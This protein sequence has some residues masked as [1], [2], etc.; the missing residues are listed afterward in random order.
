MT[1]AERRQ[2]AEVLKKRL[3]AYVH[4]E[5]EADRKALQEIWALG[6]AERVEA[7]ECLA[8][9]VR[10]A[11]AAGDGVLRLRCEDFSAKFR[12]GEPLFLGEGHSIESGLPVVFEGYDLERGEVRVRRDRFAAGDREEIPEASE[13]Q[14]DKRGRHQRDLLLAGV[15]SVFRPENEDVVDALLGRR[16]TEPDASRRLAGEER[17][18]ALGLTERQIEALGRTVSTESVALVH[19]PPG[20]G[21]TRVLAEAALA[22]ARRRCRLF[23]TA[24]THRA[25]DNLLLSIRALS[26]ELPVFK[27]R[28]REEPEL[29]RARISTLRNL[30][31]SLP[32]PA[33]I[34]GTPYSVCR[35]HPERRFHFVLIDEA[36][37]MP[38][39]HGAIA[40]TQ[41]RRYIVAGDP[42]QLSPVRVGAHHDPNLKP[43]LFE[44]LER[45]YESVLLDR[46]FR[47]TDGLAGW[48]SEEFYGGQLSSAEGVGSARL[49][50]KD[51]GP[52]HEVLSPD[53]PLVLARV[54]HEGRTR[55]SREEAALVADLVSALLGHHE[56]PASEIA[57]LTPFRAQV[58]LIRHELGRRGLRA[59]DLV[60]D[61][62][63]RMQG[64]ER[65]VVLLSL[66]SSDRD[67]LEG[68]A[69]FFFDPGRLNVAL[70]R[71]R[72]KCIIVASRHAFRARPNE[73]PALLAATRFKRL[74]AAAFVVDLTA[75]YA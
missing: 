61:T 19:G 36:G 10:V 41:A 32:R 42:R 51:G 73:L 43:S 57:V 15:D 23:V 45:H 52:L 26:P 44:F 55:R 39:V 60:V 28:R 69:E 21:K 6:V 8:G 14:L 74:S 48:I 5:A 67:Y 24:Y 58:R 75:S 33:V 50:A 16:R 12:E 1:D 64:Q 31:G 4:H 9:L 20:T 54:D 65:E 13:L 2:E 62:V 38:V 27:V 66:A 68:Q 29:A 56:I 18:R 71:A 72:T 49:K 59:P 34:G 63:E 47:L 35:F 46:S 40:M 70:S 3:L 25:I 37:Q 17:G 22:L 30:D 7:G 11:D 53:H